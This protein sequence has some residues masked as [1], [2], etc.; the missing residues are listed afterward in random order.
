M[1]KDDEKVR[2]CRQQEYI[3]KTSIKIGTQYVLN[4]KKQERTFITVPS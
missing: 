3:Y 2:S 4:F 1:Y